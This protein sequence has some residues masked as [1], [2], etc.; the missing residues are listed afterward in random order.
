MCVPYYEWQ[1][2]AG[3][4]QRRQYLDAKLAAALP[5]PQAKAQLA[6]SAELAARWVAKVAG[7]GRRGVDGAHRHVHVHGHHGKGGQHGHRQHSHSHARSLG[8]GHSHGVHSSSGGGGRGS[9]HGGQQLQQQGAARDG[10]QAEVPQKEPRADRP[11]AAARRRKHR[12]PALSQ[13]NKGA[14]A[15]G[16]TDGEG[17]SDLCV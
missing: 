5:S 11:Q 8:H 10:S 1:A 4:Q 7:D 12:R 15:P 16:A 2:L 17:G 14:I 9:V 13:L 6:Q 3:E